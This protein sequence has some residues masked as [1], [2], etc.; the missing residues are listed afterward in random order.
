MSVKITVKFDDSWDSLRR[1]AFGVWEVKSTFNGRLVEST[2]FDSE[3][4][5]QSF[6]AALRACAASDRVRNVADL[7][8]VHDAVSLVAD[9]GWLR[10]SD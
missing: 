10:V 4:E 7:E 1:S 5:A 6:A 9:A 3:E 2:E 8:N